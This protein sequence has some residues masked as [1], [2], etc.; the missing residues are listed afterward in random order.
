M[1]E[2]LDKLQQDVYALARTITGVTLFGRQR[3]T[4]PS[5]RKADSAGRDVLVTALQHRGVP[6]RLAN[7]AV[8]AVVECWKAALLRG[9]T[10]SL[11]AGTLKV[12]RGRGGNRVAF[13]P[14][15]TEICPSEQFGFY[16]KSIMVPPNADTMIC[17]RCGS[18]WMAEV[19]FRRYA[20]GT[21][22]SRVGESYQLLPE[23]EKQSAFVCLCG[24]PFL[25]PRRRTTSKFELALAQA[26]TYTKVEAAFQ[27]GFAQLRSNMMEPQDASRLN[28]R[29]DRLE[30]ELADLRQRRARRSEKKSGQKQN[31][32]PE[33]KR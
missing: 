10:V 27:K 21:Y 1:E 23:E 3:W 26:Q 22:G 18:P 25:N 5:R 2:R 4:G 14:T 24:Y 20:A 33:T 32:K 13:R 11:E 8:S 29:L 17:E 9:E 6:F 12:K 19:D 30:T 28:S 31:N 15:S 7:R 16:P